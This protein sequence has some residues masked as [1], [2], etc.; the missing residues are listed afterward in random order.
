MAVK[1]SGTMSVL[2]MPGFVAES[3]SNIRVVLL[4]FMGPVISV[5]GMRALI[6]GVEGGVKG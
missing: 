1:A 4:E 3:A 2:F 5:T 6:T